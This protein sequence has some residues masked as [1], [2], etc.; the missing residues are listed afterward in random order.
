MEKRSKING[1]M[2]T[3]CAFKVQPSFLMQSLRSITISLRSM[4]LKCFKFFLT[5]VRSILSFHSHSIS[6]TRR[7]S[8]YSLVYF[9]CFQFLHHLLKY[10]LVLLITLAIS[11]KYH[12]WAK[13]IIPYMRF[14]FLCFSNFQEWWNGFSKSK[15]FHLWNR[16]HVLFIWHCN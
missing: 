4:F 5:V 15:T 12:N 14:H 1:I 3:I 16:I 13:Y 9:V 2:R 8:K 6:Y 7:A 11:G 10:S